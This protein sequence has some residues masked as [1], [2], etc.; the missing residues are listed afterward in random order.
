MSEPAVEQ[1]AKPLHVRV[2]EAL[3]WTD[4]RVIG[5][6]MIPGEPD[7]YVGRPPGNVLIG[8]SGHAPV[9][10]YDTDWSVTGPLIERLGIRV[11]VSRF[12]GP[13]P[14]EWQAIWPGDS[15]AIAGKINA[16]AATSLGAVCELILALHAAGKLERP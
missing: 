4:L 9:P 3:G 12:R 2:A 11:H 7:D 1:A 10:R 14:I 15:W 13:N 6:C 16:K 5:N 8:S